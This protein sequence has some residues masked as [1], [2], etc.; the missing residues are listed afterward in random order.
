MTIMSP[1]GL[2][3]LVLYAMLQGFVPPL[4][5]GDILNAVEKAQLGRAQK[6]DDRIKVYQ[7]ASSRMQRSVHA[8][9]S[10]D[11]FSGVPEAVKLWVSLLA[12]SLEDIDAN[13]Q[14]K[15]KSKALIRYEIQVRKTLTEFKGYKAKAPIEQQ[16]EFDAQLASAEIIRKRFVEIVFR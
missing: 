1:F 4:L 15:K 14:A 11:D 16:D 9:V 7:S 12:G 2:L 6:V 13:V 10:S 3:P 5:E 8:A